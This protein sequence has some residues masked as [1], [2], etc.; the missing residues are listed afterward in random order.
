ML[1]S[2]ICTTGGGSTSLHCLCHMSHI[3]SCTASPPRLSSPYLINKGSTWAQI[4]WDALDC[5][6]GHQINAYDVQWRTRTYYY[7]YSTVARVSKR[8]FTFRD[9]TPST[10]Y[11]FRVGTVSSVS[12]WSSYSP[13]ISVTTHTAGMEGVY[14]AV[15]FIPA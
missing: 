15:E 11:Y 13:V 3:H 10:E 9:L 6:G 2:H 12:S 14:G 4:G 8:I 1:Q 5:D 7:S